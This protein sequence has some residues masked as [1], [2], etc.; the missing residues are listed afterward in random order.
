MGKPDWLVEKERIE[1]EHRR[2]KRCINCEN[3]GP[4][5]GETNYID[6]ERKRQP[7]YQCLLHPTV[8]LHYDTYACMDYVRRQDK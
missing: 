7:V 1:A 3:V 6:K 4:I 5:V 2:F 8:R